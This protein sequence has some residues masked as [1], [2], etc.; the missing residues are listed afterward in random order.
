[1]GFFGDLYMLAQEVRDKRGT[2]RMVEWFRM[3]KGDEL[4]WQQLLEL[5]SQAQYWGPKKDECLMAGQERGFDMAA[6]NEQKFLECLDRI[7]QEIGIDKDELECRINKALGRESILDTEKLGFE[8]A[9]AIMEMAHESLD[10]IRGTLRKPSQNILL[11]YIALLLWIVAKQASVVLPK[12]SIQSTID[13][14]HGVTFSFLE[15]TGFRKIKMLGGYFNEKTFED[16]MVNRFKLYYYA[17]NVYSSMKDD[18][19]SNEENEALSQVSEI[20][21]AMNFIVCCFADEVEYHN[22][23]PNPEDRAPN[24]VCVL[25]HYRRFSEKVNR[26]LSSY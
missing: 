20:N 10:D 16:W 14:A 22:V 25:N 2:D 9:E 6:K 21:V 19:C 1:M 15:D 5:I 17:W 23:F 13:H 11:E 7:E 4:Y 8:L 3:H 24:T 18:R 12:E 26:V